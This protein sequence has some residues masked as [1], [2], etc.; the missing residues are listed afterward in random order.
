MQETFVC[1]GPAV[2]KNM[3]EPSGQ[4]LDA[5]QFSMGAVSPQRSV[6]WWLAQTPDVTHPFCIKQPLGRIVSIKLSSA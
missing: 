4:T 2:L 6:F 1:S 5:V 3:R